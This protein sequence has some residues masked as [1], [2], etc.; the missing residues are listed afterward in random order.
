M[1]IDHRMIWQCIEVVTVEDKKTYV[2]DRKRKELRNI[3]DPTDRLR[4]EERQ[5]GRIPTGGLEI[6]EL[7]QNPADELDF[8][9]LDSSPEWLES[10]QISGPTE[11]NDQ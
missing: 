5:S 7:Y 9:V 4:L 10:L 6:L 1:K 11:A 3:T 2:V 8:V